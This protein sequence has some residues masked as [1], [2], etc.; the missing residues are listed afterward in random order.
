[1]AYVL[2]LSCGGI[3]V[4]GMFYTFRYSPLLGANLK[5]EFNDGVYL[6]ELRRKKLYDNYSKI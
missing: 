5:Q 3:S 4:K 2:R 1:M 6:G